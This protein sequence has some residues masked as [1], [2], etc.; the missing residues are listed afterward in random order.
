MKKRLLKAAICSALVV[1]FA[2][3]ALAAP[4]TTTTTTT[5]TVPSATNYTT[6]ANPFSDVPA[7]NW[8]YGAV[9]QLAKDGVVNGYPDGAFKGDR[10]VTRYEMAQIIAKAMHQTMTADQKAIVDK[11][12]REYGAELDNLGVKV[13]G[14]QRQ[15]DNQVKISGDARVRYF[16][17]KDST[18]VTDYRAR[19]SFDGNINH[20]MKFDARLSSGNQNVT[21]TA[22]SSIDGNTN[23]GTIK[24]DTANVTFNT[25]DLA[26]TVGRQD[27]KLGS[28]FLSDTQMNGVSTNLGNLNVFG[29][30]ATSNAVAT[31]AEKVYG[32][33]YKT[34]ILGA[35]VTA[36]YLKN[37][38]QGTNVYG[39]NTSFA[40]INGVTANAEYY[41]NNG[42][43][44]GSAAAYGAKLD[45]LGLSATY[46]DVK[47]GIFSDMS[48]MAAVTTNAQLADDTS[49]N[50]FAAVG[51]KGMEYQYDKAI[52]KNAG[53]TVK[54]Q[55]FKDQ[56]GAKIPNR[57]SAAVNVKF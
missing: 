36:D 41:K 45:N 57:A 22:V 30:V 31:T 18:D 27:L 17:E 44:G 56:N 55:D 29:G 3:P 11:L 47:P 38:T 37:T 50:G 26:T 54:Y 15:I 13:D 40:L 6:T 24:L 48:T 20:N 10:T 1:A 21:G 46:R 39:L 51:F 19:V 14:L 9:N 49:S 52:N 35:D 2:A 7:N 12:A 28:G 8:A 53:L 16:N 34:N 42:I 4:A 33:E 5:T 23:A 43:G 25:L 32:A